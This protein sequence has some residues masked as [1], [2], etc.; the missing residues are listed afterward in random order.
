M[1]FYGLLQ[2]EDGVSHRFIAEGESPPLVR[3]KVTCTQIMEGGDEF[4]DID[5]I[6]HC[7]NLIDM[8]GA[9]S[10]FH[11]YLTLISRA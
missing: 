2:F 8:Q 1:S 5:A 11:L 7:K 10:Y 3:D 6:S 9:F 4:L